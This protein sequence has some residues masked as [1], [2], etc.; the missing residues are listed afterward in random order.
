MSAR[1]N[2]ILTET[3]SYKDG[4][5]KQLTKTSKLFFYRHSDGHPKG[6]IPTLKR[7]IQIMKNGYFE[8]NLSNGADWLIHFGK[9][10]NGPIFPMSY[11]KFGIYKHGV[12]E[13]TTEIHGHIDFLYEI[14]M[15]T[16]ELVIKRPIYGESGKLDTWVVIDENEKPIIT[17]S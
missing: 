15:G 3:Y 12:Y 7:F 5:G 1:C 10:D 4:N 9:D 14:D 2:V 8:N 17:E 6:T 11:E 13:P 16:A